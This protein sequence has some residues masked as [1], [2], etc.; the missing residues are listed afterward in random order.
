MPRKQYY[1][2][3]KNKPGYINPKSVTLGFVV[4]YLLLVF[5]DS[6]DILVKYIQGLT[7][8]EDSRKQMINR[9]VRLSQAWPRITKGL[10]ALIIMVVIWQ[11]LKYKH[12]DY[13]M[14][15]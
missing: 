15:F 2:K 13:L 10:Y 7:I 12:I 14:V 8:D 3:M 9:Y 6:R 11:K 1:D 5:L 4:I